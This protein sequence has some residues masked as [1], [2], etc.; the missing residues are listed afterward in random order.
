MARKPAL[1]IDAL[2]ALG[3]EKL[4]RL[5]LDE[6]EQNAAFRKVVSA[7]LASSK[8]PEAIAKIVDRRLSALERA[9]SFIEWDKA[10]AFE[11]DLSATVKIAAEE[12]GQASPDMA[13][14]RLL[15]FI[16]THENVF[17]R[18]DDSS[19]RVQ[20]VYYTAIQAIGDLAVRL[21][22]DALAQLPARVM[23]SLGKSFHGYLVDLA[24]AVAPHLPATVLAEW[25]GKLAREHERMSKGLDE[26]RDWGRL[27]LIGQ[28]RSVRQIIAEARGDIAGLL[29]LEAQ[30]PQ[31]T[32]DTSGMA[33]RLLDAGRAEE[34]L[35]W[36]RKERRPAISR[37]RVT[38]L[39]DGLPP[40]D[41]VSP[42][43]ARLE[44]RILEALRDREGA[45]TLRW[46]SFEATLQASLLRD[47]LDA[48]DDFEEF[49][50]LDRAFAHALK[51][52]H[53]HLALDFLLEWPKLDVAARLVVDNHADWNGRQYG[54]LV[55]AAEA[56]EVEHP[57]AATVLYRACL[58][59]ILAQARSKAYGHGGRHLAKL[60][61]LAT[62]ID[63]DAF[64]SAGI[65]THGEYREQLRKQH[66]RKAAFW[67][68]VPSSG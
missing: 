16:A 52:R 49:D 51:V 56:L 66:G 15:R 62:G 20:D 12:L 19:G 13:V 28:Y 68:N 34:A 60:D 11:K 4:A 64:A 45:Q 2:S 53:R 10:K 8:G 65:V 42:V 50:A 47:Y 58:D 9:R 5:V 23:S 67:A 14:D 57:L 3:P 25:D 6:A 30:K 55:P 41:P 32:Q 44:A 29:A 37:W 39:A 27:S 24:K 40:R 31:H 22:N 7:A 61:R 43:H 26:E 36:I 63:A 17:D 38:D 18:V 48:L 1:N 35:T 21:E 54:L 33:Q 59:E 46:S